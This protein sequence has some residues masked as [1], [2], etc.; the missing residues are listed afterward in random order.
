MAATGA[1][2]AAAA[3]ATAAGAAA[4]ATAGFCRGRDREGG[5]DS[6]RD[7]AGRSLFFSPSVAA[8]GVD[9]VQTTPRKSNYPFLGLD[10][11]RLIVLD[12]WRVDESVLGMSTQLL[13]LEGKPIVIA[14]P[15]DQGV[16][17]HHVYLGTA[18]IFITTEEDKPGSLVREPIAPNSKAKPAKQ[19]SSDHDFV[20]TH[21]RRTA[22]LH[23]RAREHT[24]TL[25]HTHKHKHTCT[26]THT[27]AHTRKA[28]THAHTRTVSVCRPRAWEHAFPI[29]I[30]TIR[31]IEYRPWKKRSDDRQC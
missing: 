30:Q 29:R 10:V 3:A 14:M 18:P 28:R 21:P 1:A 27:R 22:P 13:W 24:R 12:A 25:T 6:G 4:A 9:M 11:K 19:P 31:F 15:Q 17:G 5:R 8:Y 20:A 23:S 7:G 2:A 16:S 26:H